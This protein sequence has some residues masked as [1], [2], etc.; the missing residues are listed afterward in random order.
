[1]KAVREGDLATLE[2]LNKVDYNHLYPLEVAAE[3]GALDSLK[4]ILNHPGM[5]STNFGFYAKL[6]GIARKH[7]QR[8]VMR[9]LYKHGFG[10]NHHDVADHIR[11]ALDDGDL[12]S[13]KFI[14]ASRYT[15][16]LMILEALTFAKDVKAI[17]WIKTYGW[18]LQKLKDDDAKDIPVELLHNNF[19]NFVLDSHASPEFPVATIKYLTNVLYQ[20]YKRYSDEQL[21][22]EINALLKKAYS[23]ILRFLIGFSDV[24][25]SEEYVAADKKGKEALEVTFARSFYNDCL[26]Q[27]K[28]SD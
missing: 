2:A 5:L 19:I 26:K 24:R 22:D 10:F 3:I 4:V 18:A 21:T 11:N 6:A 8:H 15:S 7:G 28:E 9:W 1:V 20:R 13:V 25:E 14:L 16:S 17:H 27:K 12:A 23:F